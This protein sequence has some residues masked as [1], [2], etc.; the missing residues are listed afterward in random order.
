MASYTVWV[1]Q[2]MV[3]H[4]KV[5]VDAGSEAEA[6]EMVEEM[7]ELS[8]YEDAIVWSEKEYTEDATV[9]GVELEDEE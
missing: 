1:D 2:P 3:K 9:R 5:C 8:E 4:C 6:K 7:I